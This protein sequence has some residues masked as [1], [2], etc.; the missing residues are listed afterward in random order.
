M[1][2]KLYCIYCNRIFKSFWEFPYVMITDVNIFDL[3]NNQKYDWHK[4]K[5]FTPYEINTRKELLDFQ[6]TK[7]NFYNSD[8]YEYSYKLFPDVVEKLKKDKNM[9]VYHNIYVYRVSPNKFK[10]IECVLNNFNNITKSYYNFVNNIDKF[11]EKMHKKLKPSDFE[12]FFDKGYNGTCI[13]YIEN[14][15]NFKDREYDIKESG[16]YVC[17]LRYNGGQLSVIHIDNIIA[18][19]E[20]KLIY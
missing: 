20:I 6:V 2:D 3:K 12:D 8:E 4:A 5:L 17:S 16:Y 1:C 18:K 7:E 15:M 19:I 10:T 13:M 11:K 14:N 9:L